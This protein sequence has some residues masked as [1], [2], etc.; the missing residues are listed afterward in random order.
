[1][2]LRA[3]NLLN[4]NRLDVIGR[5]LIAQPVACVLQSIAFGDQ[6]PEALLTVRANWSQ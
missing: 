6:V 2:T 5:E 3:H 1:M 4:R